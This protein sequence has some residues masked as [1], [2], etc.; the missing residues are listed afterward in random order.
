LQARYEAERASISLTLFDLN[1]LV[2]AFI[3]NYE[4]MRMSGK[5]LIPLSS[6]S[7]G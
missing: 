7:Q 4:N 1:D 2:V 3:E 6:L 5:T